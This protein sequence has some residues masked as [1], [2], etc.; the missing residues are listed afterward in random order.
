MADSYLVGST[1][2]ETLYKFLQG[3]LHAEGI[4]FLVA[5]YAAS[6]QVSTFLQSLFFFGLTVPCFKLAYLATE[7]NNLVDAAFGPTDLFLFDLDKVISKLDTDLFQFNWITRQVCQ[8]ELSRMSSEQF[9]DFCLLLG[10]P[11]LRTFPPFENSTYPGKG[12]NIREAINLFNSTGRNALALCAQFEED[13]RVQSL[14]YADRFKRAVITVK[15]H[16]IMDTDG[17]VGPFRPETVSSDLHEL[18]GQRL[19]EELYFYISKGIVGPN[20][21][22]W[23]TA[24]EISLTLP[25]GTEDS[26]VYRQLVTE[27]LTPIRTQA[28]CLLSNSLHRF[29][30][31]KAIQIR[32]WYGDKSDRSINLKNHPSVKESINSRRILRRKGLC[33]KFIIFDD[34]QRGS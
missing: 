6:A 23:L 19:P 10:S 4:N 3:I 12:L 17:S 32:P 8:D 7:P 13:Q 33:S 20:V 27:K 34:C 24:G 26:E 30:Q 14:N 2:P 21:P 31:T 1:K 11:Y 5:P 22:N 9:F 29:Y 25:L 16:I 18:I 28:L 15:H